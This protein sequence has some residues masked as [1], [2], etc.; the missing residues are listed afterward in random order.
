[1]VVVT[2]DQ[3]LNHY[4]ILLNVTVLVAEH[5]NVTNFIIMNNFMK[6]WSHNHHQT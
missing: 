2:I 6:Y 1:M 5:G 4:A 3:Q